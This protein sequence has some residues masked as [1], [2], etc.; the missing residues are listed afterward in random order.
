[1]FRD[2]ALYTSNNL[3]AWE[4]RSLGSER[5]AKGGND[6][7]RRDGTSYP[8]LSAL[9]S[10]WPSPSARSFTSWAD[11]VAGQWRLVGSSS[12]ESQSPTG[13]CCLSG[14]INACRRQRELALSTPGVGVASA[15]RRPLDVPTKP[16]PRPSQ[17]L[18]PTAAC[19]APPQLTRQTT[20][21]TVARTYRVPLG[22]NKL[23]YFYHDRIARERRRFASTGLSTR[24][25]GF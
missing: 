7:T 5:D 24:T 8:P 2:D 14:K 3:L 17:F 15:P 21:S 9:T 11:E 10:S 18:S 12:Q 22:A 20:R 4:S 25:F 13:G 19:T 23:Y 1:M 6:A 16:S